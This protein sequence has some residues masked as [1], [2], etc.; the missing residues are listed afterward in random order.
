MIYNKDYGFEFLIFNDNNPKNIIV[1]PFVRKDTPVKNSNFSN[2]LLRLILTFKT[3]IVNFNKELQ[4][5][6]FKYLELNT[7]I[8]KKITPN[9]RN[10]IKIYVFILYREKS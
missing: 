5:F 3:Y 8:L 6:D 2:I 10:K 1:T 7:K 9:L 4:D